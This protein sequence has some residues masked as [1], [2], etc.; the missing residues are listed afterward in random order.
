MV[1]TLYLNFDISSK[2]NKLQFE[3]EQPLHD[4]EWCELSIEIV[5]EPEM[6]NCKCY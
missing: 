3:I 1:S 6:L 2:L 5:L 4:L